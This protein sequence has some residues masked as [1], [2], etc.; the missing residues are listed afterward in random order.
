MNATQEQPMPVEGQQGVTA[1]VIA[2]VEADERRTPEQRA[3]IVALVREREA[4][5]IATYNTTLKTFNRRKALR[6]M[7]EEALDFAQYAD[8]ELLEREKLDEQT[9]RCH[10]I[11]M[12]VA[13]LGVVLDIPEVEKVA[14]E[15]GKVLETWVGEQ[16]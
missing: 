15:A 7:R 2:E 4:K 9:R 1:H 13:K 16:S 12:A 5:G 3:R 8:Q 11:L 6:D 10:A 14:G